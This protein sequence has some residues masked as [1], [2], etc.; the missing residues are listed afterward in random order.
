[1]LENLFSVGL[2][3][4]SFP[5]L[6]SRIHITLAIVAVAFIV[7]LI[8]GILL[9]AARIYRLPFAAPA[10]AAYVSF[11][12]GI[13]L[14][15]LLYIV[16]IGLPLLAE[17]GGI[18]INRLDSLWFVMIAYSMNS[19]AF[20]SEIIRAAVK[21]IDGGQLEA[22]YAVGMT[23]RQA[24]SRIIV[25]QALRISLPSLGN[26]IISLLKDTSLAYTL[27]VIDIVGVIK[28]ISSN[29]YRSLEAYTAAA[30]IFFALSFLLE[31]MFAKLQITLGIEQIKPQ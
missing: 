22:A 19:A 2:F 29:T 31:R 8:G 18:H 7:G 26:N 4:T 23:R 25:P 1:M 13:P 5:T 11:I 15:V 12:R 17:A 21:G 20:L 24:F 16:Y 10:A 28:A 6:L 14:L 30:V 27:G 9:A 3:F